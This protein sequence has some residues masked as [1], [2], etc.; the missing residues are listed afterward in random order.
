MKKIRCLLV[1]DEPLAI[2]LLEHHIGQVNDLVVAATCG[3]A[4]R[5]LEILNTTEIDL[6]FLDIRMPAI[7]GLSFL[8]MITFPPKV[9]ITTAFREYAL[10]GY[11]LDIVDYLLKPITLERFLKA[12]ERYRRSIAPQ[13]SSTV[14]GIESM[15]PLFI[16][17][18][19]KKIRI[20]PAEILFIESQKDYLKIVTQHQQ[21]MAKGKISE[22][23]QTLTKSVFLRVH[24]SYIINRHNVTAFNATK[25]VLGDVTLPVG[26]L[27]KDGVIAALENRK[28]S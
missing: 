21:I 14:G 3:N 17:S 26:E 8:K 4:I 22:M 27:Y 19:Y 20:D 6:V 28:L 18:G 25:V 13:Q 10:E 1:D 15:S 7:D 2:R 11:D 16:K 23:E 24:R 9:I 5:A 12:V